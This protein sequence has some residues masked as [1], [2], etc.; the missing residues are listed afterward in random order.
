MFDTT[1]AYK[2]KGY[3]GIAFRFHSWSK[4]WATYSE[5]AVDEDGNFYLTDS[6]EGEW[7]EQVDGD[8]ACFHMVGDDRVFTFDLSDV[9]PIKDSEFCHSCGQ[10]GCRHNTYEE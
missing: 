4:V 5:S 6:D 9:T 8:K 1:K 3:L 7:I 2:V 10:I